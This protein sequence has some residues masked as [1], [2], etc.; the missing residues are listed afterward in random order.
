MEEAQGL[1]KGGL[2][3]KVLKRLTAIVV[4]GPAERIPAH[5]QALDS[6]APCVCIQCAWHEAV[7]TAAAALAAPL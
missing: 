1:L 6:V 5:A 7:P 4:S 2:I 3:D